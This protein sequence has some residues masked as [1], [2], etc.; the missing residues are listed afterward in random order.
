MLLNFDD[1]GPGPVV[2]LLHG[3]PLD[4][5]IWEFQKGAIGSEYRIIAP[6]LRGHGRTA[7]PAGTYTVDA[8]AD[9][10]LETLD[11]LGITEPVVLGGLS[12]GGYI[13]LS[14]VA[15]YPER[16]RGLMLFDTRATADT[17][18]TARVRDELARQVEKTGSVETVV[19]AML[20]VMF[21][22]VTRERHADLIARVGEQMLR[23]LPGGI[24]GTLRGLAIRPDRA[25]VL[26]RIRV[27]TLVVVGEKD[28]ITPT[29][30]SRAMAAAI[31]GARL[32]EVADAGHLAPIEN[33]AAV[34]RA[35]L[36]FLAALA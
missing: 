11:A 8:M 3:F 19:E 18:E 2:V 7:A 6:D 25:A 26:T 10:V 35:V 27:P 30:Q 4:N 33:P 31:P 36:E 21:A 23:T 12:M 34:N 5:N 13:A 15:R 29:D 20:P 28:A 32:V 22:P 1:V 9:D 14:I 16:L 17:P 24:V